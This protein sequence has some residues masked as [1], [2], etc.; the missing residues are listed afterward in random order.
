MAKVS[1][2]PV[3]R[4][5]KQVATLTKAT[6]RNVNQQAAKFVNKGDYGGAEI[7]VGLAKSVNEFGREV[8]A[9]RARWRGLV[10]GA[11]QGVG[12]QTALW[13]YYRPILRVL[14][15]LGGRASARDLEKRFET[16]CVPSL[17]A[18]DLATTSSGQ[19]RW[20][21][22]L[23]R[24]RSAMIKEGSLSATGR[25]CGALPTLA[26]A[27]RI[28]SSTKH[29]RTASQY[30]RAQLA[31][32]RSPYMSSPRSEKVV[33]APRSLGSPPGGAGGLATRSQTFLACRGLAL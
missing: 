23:V 10:S 3:A 18:A 28:G 17:K 9:M 26:S 13:E 11:S 7:L 19:A 14:E 16:A 5:L 8:E 30:Q 12:D 33:V 29:S 24:A 1:G 32:G 4:A 22:A 2:A 15:E 31:M 21:R 25:A 20:K 6:V 27:R